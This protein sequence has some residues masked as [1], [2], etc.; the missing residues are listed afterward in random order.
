MKSQFVLNLQ[1]THGMKHLRVSF[2]QTP[3]RHTSSDEDEC[4]Q[5]P[6]E[7]PAKRVKTYKEAVECLED[8]RVFLE[9]RG[10]TEAATE[11]DILVNKVTT[12]Q[13]SQMSCSVQSSITSY[14]KPN[15]KHS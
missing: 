8:V 6:P 1:M 9:Q 2:S 5:D 13:C 10:H 15:E 11:A 7:P 4:E 12:L 3:V 14:F